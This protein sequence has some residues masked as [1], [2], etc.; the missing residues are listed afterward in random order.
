MIFPSYESLWEV[1]DSGW[2][3]R[4][5]EV[6]VSLGPAL[7][8][9][10]RALRRM[11]QLDTQGAHL[12]LRPLWGARRALALEALAAAGFGP[13]VFAPVTEG[14]ALS[15]DPR[16]ATTPAEWLGPFF[17]GPAER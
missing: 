9:R 7:A 15:G 12:P 1:I 8:G 2:L 16:Y 3:L 4:L 11:L 5:P 10:I 14:T 6:V 17:A 13:A